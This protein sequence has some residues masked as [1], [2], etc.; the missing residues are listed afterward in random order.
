MI[1]KKNKF[2]KIEEHN[3]LSLS[4]TF[5]KKIIESPKSRRTS[6]KKKKSMNNNNKL[7]N[8]EQQ[9]PKYSTTKAREQQQEAENFIKTLKYSK[10]G[11]QNIKI[12][13]NQEMKHLHY[14][15]NINRIIN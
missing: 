14:N 13:N 10:P 6:Q 2:T 4:K 1:Y 9:N 8:L 15:N 5:V 11:T 3:L 7:L 12:T